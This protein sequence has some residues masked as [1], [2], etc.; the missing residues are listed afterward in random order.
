MS[1]QYDGDGAWPYRVAC[2]LG[3]ADWYSG[4]SG[5]LW[6]TL[7]VPPGDTGNGNN[8]VGSSET[9]WTVAFGDRSLS[10]SASIWTDYINSYMGSS[11]TQ[12]YYTNHSF[13]YRFGP[14]TFINYLMERRPENYRTPELAETP[15]QPMKAVKGLGRVYGQSD[16][17]SGF[18][19]PDL[20]GGLRH[21]RTPRDR[22]DR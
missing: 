18:G 4:H 7:G 9:E 14:K 11:S 10:S 12:L 3:L 5:G 17:R 13:R 6:E 21:E 22:S 16:R 2:A 20:A 8:W 19:R 1:D 15:H